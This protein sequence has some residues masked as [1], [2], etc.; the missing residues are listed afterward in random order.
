MFSHAFNFFRVDPELRRLEQSPILACIRKI[1]VVFF[2]DV[3]LLQS[4]PSFG[5][6]LFCAEIR[7]R[8]S[9]ACDVLNKAPKL[10]AVVVSW[11]DS[12]YTGNWEEK[13]KILTPLGKLVNAEGRE[14]P[15]SFQVGKINGPMILD[16]VEF[17][18]ALKNIIGA[19]QRL[20]YGNDGTED[21]SQSLRMLAFDPRQERHQLS[22]KAGSYPIA[23]TTRRGWRGAPPLMTAPLEEA[24]EAETDEGP[25]TT[26][27]ETPLGISVSESN[28]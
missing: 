3:L 17:A 2:C 21:A 19:E 6:D 28:N 7:K 23:G 1:E 5:L 18:A 8:A 11:C 25:S 12:T 13:A 22:P 20:D 24:A 10:R 4:Y 27:A 16:R 9:R 26:G 14:G 15:V